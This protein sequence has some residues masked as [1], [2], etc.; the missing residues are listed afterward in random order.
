MPDCP[1]GIGN[2]QTEYWNI[3][4]LFA[5]GHC[6]SRLLPG[7]QWNWI[8]GSYFECLKSFSVF[9]FRK[10]K[11]KTLLK[12]SWITTTRIVRK[13]VVCV[14]RID[15][16]SQGR[17]FGADPAYISALTSAGGLVKTRCQRQVWKKSCTLRN[18]PIV[19][20]QFRQ[21]YTP[22][23]RGVYCSGLHACLQTHSISPTSLCKG[24]IWERQR[25]QSIQA[26]PRAFLWIPVPLKAILLTGKNCLDWWWSC[27]RKWYGWD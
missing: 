16:D 4:S 14:H 6:Q 18:L 24:R 25:Q 21:Q 5:L 19:H 20:E 11:M 2:P 7:L 23:G 22:P 12:R 15:N 1:G 8:R 27:L 9:S 3:Q 10:I 13:N 17:S 26:M